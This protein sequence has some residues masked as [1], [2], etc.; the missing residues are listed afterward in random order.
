[1]AYWWCLDHKVV[2]EGLGCGS[3]TRIGPYDTPQQA[4]SALDRIHQREDEQVEKDKQIEKKW[5]PKKGWF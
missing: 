2:E 3:T 4:A 1:M 5:G